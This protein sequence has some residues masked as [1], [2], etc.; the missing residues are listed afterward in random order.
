GRIH[1]VVVAATL[2]D[3][4]TGYGG[5]QWDLVSFSRVR[6]EPSLSIRFS[7]VELCWESETNKSYQFQYRS[8]L[9][10]NLWVGFGSTIEGD[11]KKMC[12]T[13]DIRVG[14][15]Q[16]FYQMITSP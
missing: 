16:R 8:G 4:T 9:T 15:P 1:K 7:Q 3:E 2:H 13:D 14:E 10:A 6:I 11:G 12:V 5:I